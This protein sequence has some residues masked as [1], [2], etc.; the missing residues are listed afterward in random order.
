[1]R[2]AARPSL[3][4]TAAALTAEAGSRTSGNRWGT[5]TTAL[6]TLDDSYRRTNF[7]LLRHLQGAVQ[8][9][10]RSSGL[11]LPPSSLLGGAPMGQR[12]MQGRRV[13]RSP[14]GCSA[15]AGPRPWAPCPSNARSSPRPSGTSFSSGV[16]LQT[17]KWASDGGCVSRRDA[18][19]GAVQHPDDGVDGQRRPL[20]PRRLARR[21]G[22][23]RRPRQPRHPPA[24]HRPVPLPLPLALSDGRWLSFPGTRCAGRWRRRRRWWST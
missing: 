18:D 11:T 19:D 1:M 8:A 9:L 12:G 7:V 17:R 21:H 10:K 2:N 13:S 24:H 22:G 3:Q 15:P 4:E 20:Q 16:G 14:L 5:L 6:Q 23:R